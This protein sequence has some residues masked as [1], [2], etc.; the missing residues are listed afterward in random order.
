[1]SERSGRFTLG[2][3]PCPNDCFIFDALIHGKID[4]EGLEF[5]VVMADVEELNRSAFDNE[6]DITKLSFNT[7]LNKTKDYQLLDSGSALGFGVGP[8]LVSKNE[9]KKAE[10]KDLK[11]AIPGKNTTANFLLTLAYPK[12]KNRVEMLFSEIED[13][14]LNGKV[15]A[16]VIIDESRF[17][18]EAK[19]LRKIVD[20][21]EWWEKET[22]SP[23]PLGGITIRRSFPRKTKQ[24]ITELIRRSVE[25][26]FGNRDSSLDFIKEN[27]QE[28]NEEVIAKH[29]DL[30]VNDFTVSLGVKGKDAIKLLFA[31]AKESGIISTHHKDLYV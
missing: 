13:A 9:Y 15:D 3:S 24:K 7:F 10:L 27:A 30:Y 22:G 26:A 12:A 5:D 31:K 6:I 1:M 19:G 11:I 4:S 20:L 8:L 28:M 16:G 21:G 25:Y 17:T 2:F 18:F 29:I 23:I 14:V